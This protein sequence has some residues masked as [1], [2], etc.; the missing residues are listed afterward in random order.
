[1]TVTYTILRYAGRPEDKTVTVTGDLAKLVMSYAARQVS[2]PELVEYIKTCKETIE[3][4]E[5]Q[6]AEI[7]EKFNI[8]EIEV[9]K[10]EDG[11]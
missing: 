7:V 11:K 10:A 9:K 6:K 8:K 5:T 4:Y 1:M 3:S 2:R